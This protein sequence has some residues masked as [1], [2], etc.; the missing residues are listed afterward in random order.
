[1]KSKQNYI[2]GVYW[3][4]PDQK[5]ALAKRAKKISVSEYVRKMIDLHI[6]MENAYPIYTSTAEIP[7]DLVIEPGQIY[8]SEG[9]RK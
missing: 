5:K 4:R 3:I 9:Y 1:M 8:Q 2:R 7:K 6:Q